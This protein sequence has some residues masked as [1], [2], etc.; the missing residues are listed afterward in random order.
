MIS[1]GPESGYLEVFGQITLDQV[2]GVD[3][4]RGK[5]QKKH[6]HEISWLLLDKKK[7][8]SEGEAVGKA[9]RGDDPVLPR[10]GG[11]YHV[12]EREAGPFPLPLYS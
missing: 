1:I 6:A 9:L 5:G 3:Q 7:M 8:P 11:L 12:V 10:P 2:E 4:E